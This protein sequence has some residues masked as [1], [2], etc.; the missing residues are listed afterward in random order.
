MRKYKLINLISGW[1]VFV[2]AAAVYL[3]TIEPTASFWDCGEFI[4]SAYKLEV[5]H[6]PGA[7]IFMLV[8]N[9]FTQFTS[10]PSQVAKMVNSMSALMSAFTI[11][12]LFWTITH[13]TKK[14]VLKSENDE[15]SLGQGI[16]VIGSGVVGALAYTFS[17]TF[18]FS[19]VEGEVYAF[20]SMLTALVFWLIL[21]WETNAHK[22][23]SEK[24]IVL[25]AYIMGLSIGVHLLGLLCIPAIVMVYYFKKNE[26][27]TWKGALL[28]LLLSFGLIVILMYG[29][30]PGFT[31]VGGW[32]EL[33]FVNTLGLSY[34]SGVVVYMIALVSSVVWALF[35]SI[36][37][38]G[39]LK[40]ARLAFVLSLALSGILFIGGSVWLWIA[41]IGVTLYL[42][43]GKNKLNPQLLNLTMSSMLVIIIGFSAYALIPIRSASNP[44]LDL[45]SPEDIFS[46]GSYLNREQYGQTPLIHGTTYLSQIDRDGQGNA[47]VTHEQKSY[48]RVIKTSPDQKDR[49][50]VTTVPSYK[51]TNTML[52]PRM[53][54]YPSKPG[55]GNHIQGYEIWG[56]VTDRGKMPT[57]FQNIQFLFSYQINYMYWRYFMWNFSG[58]QNDTQG[59]GG[60]TKGNWI[61]G[62]SFIDSSI[63]GLGPQDDIAPDVADSKGRNKFYMLPLIL[64][65]MGIIYQ[66]SL[67]KREKSF[68]KHTQAW[69]VTSEP[70]L[71]SKGFQSFIIVFLLFFMTGLAIVLY[72]NQTP[73]EPRE[74]D[75]AYAGSFYAFA[76]WIGMGVTGISRFL[77]NYVKNTTLV[78]TLT[79]LACLLVPIQMVSQTWDDHDR[80]GRTLAR[81]TGMNYLSCVEPNGIIF[82]NGD[83]DTYPLWYVQE[84]E[85]FRTDVRVANLSFLQTEWYVDQLVRKAYESEPLPIQWTRDRYSGEAGSAAYII[86]KKEI[87]EAL[88]RNNVPPMSYSQYYDVNAYRDTISLKQTME[89]LRTGQNTN[90]QNPFNTGNLQII[91][92]NLLY[93]DVDTAKVDWKGMNAKPSDKMYVSLGN[94]SAAYRLE[95]MMLE[96]L[97]NTNDDNWKRPL[98]FATTV[99]RNLYMNLQDKNFSLTGL[100]YQIVPGIPQNRAVNT[101][102][103]YDNMMNKFR[104]GGLEHNPNI[105]LDETCRRMISTFRM[106]FNQLIEALI[107]EGKNDKALAALDKATTVMAASAVP[108]GNDGILYSRAYYQLNEKQKADDLMSGIETRVKKNLNWYYRLSSSQINN[109]MIDIY[110]NINQLLLLTS[111]YQQYN[112]D[113]YATNVEELIKL[114]K[115]S[116]S[117][118][119]NYIGD[120]ILKEVADGSIR[121]F[122]LFEQDTTQ[123][124]LEEATMQQ[125]LHLMQ[126]YSPRL[127]QQYNNPQ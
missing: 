29:I 2:I 51:Y 18:W 117:N 40:R 46:L 125:T 32:F 65:I 50:Q 30:V 80:S 36:S 6:P 64:G 21:K 98:Y 39:N 17:D 38:R 103:A 5:G 84:T 86:S 126:Q 37:K 108:Y 96:L 41:L 61:T 94:K 91:P 105:Y 74:R 14:L 90:P 60:M 112:R 8:A 110:S 111:V 33:F 123:Q 55:F 69:I 79:S 85:G 124:A 57:F 115:D 100:A 93:L 101:D 52:L 3:L 54:S 106:F 95:L 58:R 13:L 25:I 122:Y 73:F 59:D 19:A 71:H 24:W 23:Y 49:Y 9:L 82:T 76:I 75:Y 72:L 121:G 104:W 22:P 118:G 116:Y 114:A 53:H 56:G 67:R 92:G 45:N 97:T 87:Q 66:L 102:K 107:D 12:F 109:S 127:L 81:D 77:K 78:T 70:L 44:P 63:L 83:N 27:P 120:L 89:N 20:S 16:A 88:Q 7:P 34:N 15:V 48:S 47:I 4:S 119:A 26:N 11:L 10:D 35:E 31:K 42:V 28:A 43:F 1:I 99:D 68:D 113:K 62:I